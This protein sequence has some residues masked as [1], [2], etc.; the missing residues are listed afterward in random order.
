[1]QALGDPL[2]IGARVVVSGLKKATYLNGKKATLTCKQGVRWGVIFDEGLNSK[3]VRPINL[4]VDEVPVE[5]KARGAQRRAPGFGSLHTI[6]LLV[7]ACAALMNDGAALRPDIHGR[8]EMAIP[9]AVRRLS[10][11]WPSRR[12]AQGECEA[13]NRMFWRWPRGLRRD[14]GEGG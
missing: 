12:A 6:K 13:G 10:R 9:G 8:I 14:G 4:M 3:A 11:E 5:Y 1:M 2:R 7:K